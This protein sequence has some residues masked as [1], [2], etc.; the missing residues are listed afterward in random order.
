M[1]SAGRERPCMRIHVDVNANAPF[2][3]PKI[4]CDCRLSPFKLLLFADDL[5]CAFL[6]KMRKS[7]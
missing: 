1:K 2:V 3:G 6:T 7:G 5:V 4:V